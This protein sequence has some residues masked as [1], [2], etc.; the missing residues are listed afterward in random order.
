[1]KISKELGDRIERELEEL[2]KAEKERKV[3][4]YNEEEAFKI[5]FGGRY[6]GCR[7]RDFANGRIPEQIK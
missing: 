4:F 7:F 2:D 6:A 5:M 3:K 1:M